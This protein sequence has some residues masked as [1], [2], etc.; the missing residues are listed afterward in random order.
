MQTLAV[1][2]K[3]KGGKPDSNLYPPSLWIKKFLQK[4]RPRTLTIMPR[5]LMKLYTYV[6]E[7][8]FQKEKII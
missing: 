2:V 3:V 8:G 5:N 6:H 7:F 1:S 4:L